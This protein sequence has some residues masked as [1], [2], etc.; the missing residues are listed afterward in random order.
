MLSFNTQLTCDAGICNTIMCSL[1]YRFA[2]DDFEMGLRGSMKVDS[3][4]IRADFGGKQVT[5]K[6]SCV[7]MEG[8]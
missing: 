2:D 6:S 8:C 5:F 1:M 7:F 4:F 3:K